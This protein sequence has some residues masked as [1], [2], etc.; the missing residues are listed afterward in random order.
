MITHQSSVE[1]QIE[2]MNMRVSECSHLFQILDI[3]AK[4]ILILMMGEGRIINSSITP[5][6]QHQHCHLSSGNKTFH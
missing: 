1:S 2:N 5:H 3:G 4:V 6:H